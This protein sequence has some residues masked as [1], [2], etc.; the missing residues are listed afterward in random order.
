MPTESTWVPSFIQGGAMSIVAFFVFWGLT[1]TFP[2]VVER[3]AMESNES[4]K[5]F[6]RA[7]AEERE[8][9]ERDFAKVEALL[10][11]NNV[12]MVLLIQTMQ[13]GELTPE[14]KVLIGP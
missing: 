10:E 13:H 9:R 14:Q 3:Y 8:A 11:R 1:K 4:R 12:L 6:L 7:L 5:D 2:S